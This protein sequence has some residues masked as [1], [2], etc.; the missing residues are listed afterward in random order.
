MSWLAGMGFCLSPIVLFLIGAALLFS[1]QSGQSD[2]GWLGTL[3]AKIG[4]ACMVIALMFSIITTIML[5]QALRQMGSTAAQ[6]TVM[7]LLEV[8]IV[9]LVIVGICSAMSG[10][11][12]TSQRQPQKQPKEIKRQP[13]EVKVCSDEIAAAVFE[14]SLV[15]NG[16][17]FPQGQTM[18]KAKLEDLRELAPLFPMVE[19]LSLQGHIG[20]NQKR[21][22]KNYLDIH[23]PRYDLDQLL[24]A[25]EANRAG[26]YSEWNALCG[27]DKTYCGQIW[28]TLI[29]TVCRQ[30]EPEKFQQVVDCLKTI[31][32]CFWL[33]E[34]PD[35]GPAQARFEDIISYFNAFAH[36]DQGHPYLHAVMLLQSKLAEQFGGEP[37]D[38]CPTL[39]QESVNALVG[40][41][42][43][44]FCVRSK[45]DPG[46]KRSYA[47][48]KEGYPA[49]PD[50]IWK[51][52]GDGGCALVFYAE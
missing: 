6:M 32:D 39:S 26:A 21:V 18:E 30:R 3:R 51:F 41:E 16:L 48:R 52:S 22:L 42:A 34:H 45:R 25:A 15:L 9:L 11:P 38:Y 7:S 50:L 24:A 31:L 13:E 23:H 12:L 28:H 10:R 19:A 5:H 20:P 44:L 17:T 2:D 14:L 36:S 43:Y 29:E 47:V 8:M 49:R 27:V 33:L 4:L 37:A 1:N 35:T 46:F 40:E